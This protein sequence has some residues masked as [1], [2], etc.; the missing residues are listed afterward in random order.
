M[1][2]T[3]VV[4]DGDGVGPE[5]SAE[6]VKALRVIGE[7]FGHAFAF[8]HRLIGGAAIDATGEALPEATLGA[9]K[10]SDAVLL[11]AV[12]GPKWDGGTVR[13]EQ[14]LLDL[15]REL[16]VFSNIRPVK[17]HA[18]L[19]ERSPLRADLVGAVDLVVVRELTG[20]VYFGRRETGDGYAIDETKYTVE[21]IER[22]ARVAGMIA[23]E[24]QGRIA[25]LDKANVLA[26]SR[27]WRA[28]VERVLTDEFPSIEF[29]HVLIDAAAMHLL[30][31]P[32]RFDVILTENMFG[33]IISDESSVLCGSIGMLGSASMGASGPG[34]FEPI[35]GSAP[36]IAGRG[37]A[38]PIGT[39]SSCSMLLRLGLGLPREADLLDAAID[40]VIVEGPRTPDL[41]GEALTAEV[42][43]AVGAVIGAIRSGVVAT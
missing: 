38:N 23:T 42:G 10:G 36:D 1:K 31:N 41:G 12:G 7:V 6:A 30:T 3:I 21:E 22:V 18:A 13:P 27:L 26:T 28:T 20:G 14:G 40:R 8:D 15:R 4:L 19:A 34:L 16:G 32:A 35:H 37:V 9:C 24:R 2:A 17:A 39:I 43:D 5:V 25:S 11:G 33:D 29:E